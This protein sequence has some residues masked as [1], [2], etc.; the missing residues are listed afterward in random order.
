MSTTT[1]RTPDRAF[2]RRLLIGGGVIVAILAIVG[3]VQGVLWA[4]V[5]PGEQVRVNADGSYGA[6]P[7]ADFHPFVDLA[8]FVL[9]GIVIGLI[10][11]AAVWQARS[12]RGVGALLVVVAGSAIG[13]ALAYWIGLA[14]VT[15]VD[16]ATVGATGK[17]QIVV[18][19]PRLSTPLVILAQPA[20]AAAVYTFLAAWNGRPDLG[21]TGID[22]PPAPGGTAF[23]DPEAGTLRTDPSPA[24]D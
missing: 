16:P 6:L 11:G 10:A 24:A 21:R 3:V 20:L 22:V 9:S 13:A 5:A 14:M 8:L 1:A 4:W 15:G 19:A 17:A 2:R 7:T 12:I 18:Q 23:T